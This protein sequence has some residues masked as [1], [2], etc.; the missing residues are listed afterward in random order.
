MVSDQNSDW[1]KSESK[2]EEYFRSKSAD[3]LSEYKANSN[4]D[5]DDLLRQ[6]RQRLYNIRCRIV[7]KKGTEGE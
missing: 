5:D 2:R 4:S 3:K 6:V 1:L 7:H